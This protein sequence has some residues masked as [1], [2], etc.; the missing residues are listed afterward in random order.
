MARI[1]VVIGERVSCD[2]ECY[3]GPSPLHLLPNDVCPCCCCCRG[4]PSKKHRR[5]SGGE[6]NRS[7]QTC[8]L[9]LTLHSRTLLVKRNNQLND[10]VLYTTSV[11]EDMYALLSNQFP[12][13]RKLSREKTFANFMVLW[14]LVKVFSVK[15]EGVASF[16]AT[17]AT[18]RKSFLCKNCIFY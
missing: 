16:S 10:S 8:N 3:R 17:K 5:F 2:V 18:I 9:K 12:Y 15:F 4:K 1:K 11:L 14:L 6:R 13:S 7:W